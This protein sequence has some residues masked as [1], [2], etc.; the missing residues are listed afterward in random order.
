MEEEDHGP[1][2]LRSRF[3]AEKYPI[4]GAKA[5]DFSDF[6]KVAKLMEKKDHLTKDGLEQIL[7]IR[8]GMNRGRR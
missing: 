2:A 1:F 5:K 8:Q 4:L 3:I 6:C 7:T